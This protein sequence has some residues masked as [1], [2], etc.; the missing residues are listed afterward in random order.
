MSAT[1]EDRS[2]TESVSVRDRVRTIRQSMTLPG[3]I[4][5]P[6]SGEITVVLLKQIS[7]PCLKGFCLFLSHSL[8]SKFVIMLLNELILHDL[9]QIIRGERHAH[10]RA[11]PRCQI[12]ILANLINRPKPLSNLINRLLNI[13]VESLANIL[14]RPEDLTNPPSL[15]LD[16]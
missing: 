12:E 15:R 10:V 14:I 3:E 16:E 13:R 2:A 9:H 5:S 7:T 8:E 1:C 4:L 6:V 11:V